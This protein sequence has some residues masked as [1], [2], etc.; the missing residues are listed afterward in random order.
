VGTT[1]EFLYVLSPK[2]LFLIKCE[3]IRRV[4]HFGFNMVSFSFEGFEKVDYKDH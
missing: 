4:E 1:G 2:I 3:D